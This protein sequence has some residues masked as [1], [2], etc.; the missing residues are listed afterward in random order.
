[1]AKN[2]S[3]GK[4]CGDTCIDKNDDCQL[5][6]VAANLL[7]TLS[8][9]ASLKEQ[10]QV[11]N[12]E[13]RKYISALESTNSADERRKIISAMSVRLPPDRIKEILE[14]EIEPG[15]TIKDFGLSDDSKGVYK[16]DRM[17][18]RQVSDQE[19]DSIYDA[20]STQQKD[21]LLP[22]SAGAPGR[23]E[24]DRVKDEWD[25]DTDAMRRSMLKT[26]LEQSQDDGTIIDPWS[27]KEL[28]MPADLDHIVPLAKGG[29]HGVAKA[30]QKANGQY[31]SENWVW[32]SP[33]VNRNYKKDR[34]I[35]DTVKA[36]VKHETEGINGYNAALDELVDDYLNNKGP[37]LKFRDETAESLKVWFGLQD[38]PPP[39]TIPKPEIVDTFTKKDQSLAVLKAARDIGALKSTSKL[40]KLKP[41]TLNKIAKGVLKS[42][43]DN[44]D[45]AKASV[46]NLAIVAK[47]GVDAAQ[48]Q[49]KKISTNKAMKSIF[50]KRKSFNEM[51]DSEMHRI[52]DRLQA[53][54]PPET[55]PDKI[56][57][58]LYERKN[59]QTMP[60]ERL[61]K[62]QW[63]WARL[64][65]PV[66][67]LKSL[68][69]AMQ[70]EVWDYFNRQF[71]LG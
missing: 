25:K 19:V 2:C 22:A 12:D 58:Y 43:N 8:L 48:T 70:K 3:K 18:L 49:M 29:G 71:D 1:M 27:G 13:T 38:P 30:G 42:M 5:S 21:L 23:G 67:D 28:R 26:L 54:R 64:G 16:L 32:T 51:T 62:A 44:L 9:G 61:S 6:A 66:P 59:T 10:N 7:N 52:V 15:K 31:R 39:P 35:H 50:K 36:L 68:T 63:T 47:Y 65:K 55:M 56:R 33:E 60:K 69:P 40:E 57:Y 46:E 34:D 20:L 45:L 17:K 53:T 4:P 41:E 24:G 11:R 14:S 37:L